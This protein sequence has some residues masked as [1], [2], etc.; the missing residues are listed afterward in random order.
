MGRSSAR[1]RSLKRQAELEV[2]LPQLRSARQWRPMSLA[3]ATLGGLIT[4]F[5]FI[6]ISGL[7]IEIPT[8]VFDM[9]AGAAGYFRRARTQFH[10]VARD[11]GGGAPGVP[12][13][14]S[15]DASPPYILDVVGVP[16][17][18]LDQLPEPRE[19]VK[20]WRVSPI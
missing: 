9:A 4:A 10:A 16:P 14:S 3:R 20:P 13:N 17:R 6:W 19:E 8:L 2:E 11:T 7:T 18:R 15:A 5:F 1:W 12:V